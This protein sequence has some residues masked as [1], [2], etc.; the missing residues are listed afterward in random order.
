MNC[1]SNIDVCNISI[2]K[3]N[4]KK[5][6]WIGLKQTLFILATERVFYS[7]LDLQTIGMHQSFFYVFHLTSCLEA[8]I[9]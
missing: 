8:D 2:T 3:K 9:N 4:K 7:S 5:L 6:F 1:I